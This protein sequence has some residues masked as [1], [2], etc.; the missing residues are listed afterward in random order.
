MPLNTYETLFLVDSTKVSNDADGVRNTLHALLEKFGGTVLV[1][2]P[3]DYNHKLTYPI[4][5]SKKGSFHIVYY[6]LDSLKQADLEKELRINRELVHRHMTLHVDPKWEEKVLGVAREDA[7]T[8]FA[9]RG[10]QEETEGGMGGSPTGET[11]GRGDRAEGGPPDG[12]GGGY[13]RGRRPE[14]AEK[15]E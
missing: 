10:M 2:R 12:E 15:P 7:G 6:T 4:Q 13:R 1:S 9:V 14:F 3:W 11:A 8:G 5:K